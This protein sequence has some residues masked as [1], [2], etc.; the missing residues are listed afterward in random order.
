MQPDLAH[1]VYSHTRYAL[2]V[3]DWNWIFYKAR[4]KIRLWNWFHEGVI[5]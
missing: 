1:I 2:V 5:P 3:E 4:K